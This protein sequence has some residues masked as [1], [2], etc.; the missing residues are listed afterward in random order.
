[1]PGYI[2]VG[3]VAILVLVV[4]TGSVITKEKEVAGSG[5]E[6]GEASGGEKK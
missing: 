4:S 2:I 6:G 1:V 3:A 5:K